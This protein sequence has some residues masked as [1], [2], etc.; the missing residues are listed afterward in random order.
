MN[1]KNSFREI[2]F[3]LRERKS[4]IYSIQSDDIFFASLFGFLPPSALIWNF[5]LF[6]IIESAAL[7]SSYFL[8]AHWRIDSAS[9]E[10]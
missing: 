3:F 7:H 9:E 2:I 5:V 6:H 4:R 1:S 8:T 10:G